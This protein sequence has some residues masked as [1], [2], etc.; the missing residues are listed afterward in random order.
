MFRSA[1]S[2]LVNID[3]VPAFLVAILGLGLIVQIVLPNSAVTPSFPPVLKA[4]RPHGGFLPPFDTIAEYPAIFQQSLF[5]P[6]RS[7]AASGAGSGADD[8]LSLI[9][10]A[11][12]GSS[13]STVLRTSDG[14]D[15][16]LRTGEELNGWRLIAA[17]HETA[18][19]RRGEETKTLSIGAPLAERPSASDAGTSTPLP[20]DSGGRRH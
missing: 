10:L 12:T 1:M 7:S 5:A 16:V 8:V 4:A 9:G 3:F 2:R 13:A 14:S 18:L 19:L 17:N 11:S 6:T 15:H 20:V